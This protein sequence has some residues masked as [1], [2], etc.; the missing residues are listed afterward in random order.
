[1]RVVVGDGPSVEARVAAAQR[2]ADLDVQRHRL[3]LAPIRKAED[4]LAQARRR[5]LSDLG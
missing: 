5:S 2:V 1:M 4:D 3:G